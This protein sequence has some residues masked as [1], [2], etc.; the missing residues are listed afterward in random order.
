MRVKIGFPRPPVLQ[1]VGGVT[2]SVIR[3]FAILAL[4]V[5]ASSAEGV[6]LFRR[7]DFAVEFSGS[8]RGIGLATRGTSQED[9]EENRHAGA[10]RGSGTGDHPIRLIRLSG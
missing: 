5:L 7:G 6:E 2:R 4:G 8:I 3:A 1:K 9:F 10:P